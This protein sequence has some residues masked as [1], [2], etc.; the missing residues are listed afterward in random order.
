MSPWKEQPTGTPLEIRVVV[1]IPTF[2][3]NEKLTSLLAQ[4]T[5]KDFSRLGSVRI[6]VVDNDPDRSAEPIARAAGT[7]YLSQPLPDLGETR[8]AALDAAEPGELVAMIDDDVFPD[9]E[10]LDELV[11]TW[12]RYRPTVVMGYVQYVWP[13]EADPW[14]V[15]GGFMRRTH[16]ATGT[17]LE[18]IATG[19]VLVDVDQV[20]ALGVS[21]AAGLGLFGGED[22]QFGFSV[23]QAGGS[24]VACDESIVRDNIPA[25]RVTRS[26]A[27]RRATSH[28]ELSSILALRGTTG[29]ARRKVQA[30]MIFGAIA[31]LALFWPQ[32]LIGRVTRD[33]SKAAVGQRKVWYAWGQLRATL[34]HHAAEYARAGS[35]GTP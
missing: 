29:I 6:L 2:R 13:E 17:R 19:N 33:V 5:A 18:T 1:V 25:Y 4:L 15:A 9:E 16:R 20:R 14:V 7:G 35:A 34:G 27:R 32:H 10:W 11:D 26:F 22:S 23:V 31:R 12:R 3:R 28:G 30:Q 24:L 21:F 8:Q